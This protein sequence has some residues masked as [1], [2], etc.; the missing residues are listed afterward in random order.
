M[1]YIVP[2]ESAP[3]VAIGRDRRPCLMLK[4]RLNNVNQCDDRHYFMMINISLIHTFSPYLYNR[5]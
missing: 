4:K 2:G 5:V 3:L 1:P